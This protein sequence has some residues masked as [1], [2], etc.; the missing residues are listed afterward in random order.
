MSELLHTTTHARLGLC[1]TG[2]VYFFFFFC[3]G[4]M[5]WGVGRAEL[6]GLAWGRQAER[7]GGKKVTVLLF[8]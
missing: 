6:G 5:N 4:W 1:R 7:K 2:G 3:C 8:F